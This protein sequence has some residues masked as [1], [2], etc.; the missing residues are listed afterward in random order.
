MNYQF[1]YRILDLNDE[2]SIQS[3]FARGGFEGEDINEADEPD[4]ADRASPAE[5]LYSHAIWC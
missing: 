2:L 5:E 4:G 3:E 1:V